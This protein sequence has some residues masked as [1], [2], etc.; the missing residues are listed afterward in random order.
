MEKLRQDVEE[1]FYKLLIKDFDGVSP[2]EIADVLSSID[3]LYTTFPEEY[4]KAK[5]RI[6][7]P[8]RF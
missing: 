1:M 8:L 6:K 2:V 5:N 4:Q 3:D 7:K